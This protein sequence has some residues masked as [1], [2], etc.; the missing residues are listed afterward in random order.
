MM[1]EVEGQKA[2][3]VMPVG[4][5]AAELD[6]YV[7]GS[8]EPAIAPEGVRHSPVWFRHKLPL[9][10]GFSRGVKIQFKL[11]LELKSAFITHMCLMCLGGHQCTAK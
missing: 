11:K 2:H 5:T 3:V 1:I 8:S 6:D 9:W 4:V 10:Q 7:G